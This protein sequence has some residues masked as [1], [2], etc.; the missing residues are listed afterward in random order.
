MTS[1]TQPKDSTFLW[2]SACFFC[3]RGG[4]G[5]D[6]LVCHGSAVVRLFLGIRSDVGVLTQYLFTRQDTCI[7]LNMLEGLRVPS[8]FSIQLFGFSVSLK[9]TGCL[10]W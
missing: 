2:E 7:E 9:L 4:E 5:G 10:G 1:G 8:P 3:L 6:V